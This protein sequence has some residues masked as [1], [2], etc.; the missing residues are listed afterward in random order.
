M[1]ASV[2]TNGVLAP[3]GR[4]P[5]AR[6]DRAQTPASPWEGESRQRLPPYARWLSEAGVTERSW[7]AIEFTR[8]QQRAEVCRHDCS[9]LDCPASTRYATWIGPREERRALPL[10]RHLQ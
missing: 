1:K 4:A 2:S 7:W 8:K 9:R 5:R 10:I 6:I 3:V